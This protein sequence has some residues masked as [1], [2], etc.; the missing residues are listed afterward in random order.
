MTDTY[1]F[2]VHHLTRTSFTV[3]GRFYRLAEIADTVMMNESGPIAS[4]IAPDIETA[5]GFAI[6]CQIRDTRRGTVD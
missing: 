6:Q 1:A 2:V 3:N 4:V 5:I